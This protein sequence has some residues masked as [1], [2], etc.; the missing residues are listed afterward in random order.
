MPPRYSYAKIRGMFFTIT[1]MLGDRDKRNTLLRLYC[2][3]YPAYAY[4]LSTEYLKSWRNI[5][6]QQ[7]ASR[8]SY[9]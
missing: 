2:H 9:A 5:D 4:R 7:R 1:H 3:D 6:Y 8:L